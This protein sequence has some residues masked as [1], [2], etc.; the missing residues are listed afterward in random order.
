[1]LRCLIPLI[2]IALCSVTFAQS[3][4]PSDP[5]ALRRT[6]DSFL[7]A[8]TAGMPGRPGVEVGQPDARLT[9]TGCSVLEAFLPPGTRAWGRISV[10]VR[11]ISGASWT[12]YIP[13]R[14]RVEGEYL[15]A[16]RA[17]GRGQVI[18]E[19]DYGV[20]R[21]DLTELPPNM[22]TDP[23]QAIGQSV[24]A[25]IAAGQPLRADWLRAPVAVQQGQI[26]KLF[27]RG[28]G[29]A[30]SHDGRALASAQSGQTVQVR[31]GG[32]QVVSGVARPGGQVEV[33]Y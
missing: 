16:A 7:R 1:M 26:V 20:M 5:E 12:V 18:A 4:A 33:V 11:C 3:A 31:T 14:I 6:A 15:V 8:Q 24:N 32:G 30:V 23:Q 19:G 2:G 17:L 13:A 22:V 21:G 29:F 27:A 28:N 10:G 9:L 25:A